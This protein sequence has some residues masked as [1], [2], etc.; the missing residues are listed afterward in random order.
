MVA[1]SSTHGPVRSVWVIAALAASMFGAV[2]LQ[3]IPPAGSILA[4]CVGGQVI[5]PSTG[6]CPTPSGPA[7]TPQDM[8]ANNSAVEGA[9]AFGIDGSGGAGFV[10]PYSPGPAGL[11]GTSHDFT[12][13]DAGMGGS[14]G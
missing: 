3:A 6:T 1:Q 14:G 4:E 11:P 7:V 12:E 13:A 10:Q 2:C 5:D 8:L 9:N